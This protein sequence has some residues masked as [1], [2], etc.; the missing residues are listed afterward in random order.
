MIL[1]RRA[2]VDLLYFI[3]TEGKRVVA[4]RAKSLRAGPTG[5]LRQRKGPGRPRHPTPASRQVPVPLREKVEE[6]LKLMKSQGIIK[7][8]GDAP[9]AWC[10]LIIAV[11]KPDG[12]VCICVDVTKLN[13]QVNR[14]M[15]LVKSPQEAVR[16]FKASDV[17]LCKL[18]FVKGY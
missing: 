6:E 16:Y 18:D 1:S 3:L 13:S 9:L 12:S 17:F 2:T 8:V 10:H 5:P 7:V 14:T 4:P 11:G 15:H